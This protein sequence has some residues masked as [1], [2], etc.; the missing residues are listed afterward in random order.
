[1]HGRKFGIFGNK[2]GEVVLRLFA[3]SRLH[4]LG[5]STVGK[6]RRKILL[7]YQIGYSTKT[8]E[9]ENHKKIVLK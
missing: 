9:N 5:H 4:C 7:M 8:V 3:E 6:A 1:M 2:N